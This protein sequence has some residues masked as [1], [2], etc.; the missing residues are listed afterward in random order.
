ML[1]TAVTP[2]IRADDS[3]PF[4]R[5]KS[6]YLPIPTVRRIIAI[7]DE[8][9]RDS[10]LQYSG[11]DRIDTE[12]SCAVQGLRDNLYEFLLDYDWD[13][14]DAI[15]VSNIEEYAIHECQQWYADHHIADYETQVIEDLE[16][17]YNLTKVEILADE[18]IKIELDQKLEFDNFWN[19][20]ISYDDEFKSNWFSLGFTTALSKETP[21]A[22][23]DA[24]LLTETTRF[25]EL[26]AASLES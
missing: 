20:T 7:L 8:Y 10:T 19:E 21:V 14:N 11:L 22:N 3:N 26:F 4:R 12:V 13:H 1:Q 5:A 9:E 18:E 2:V 23:D 25:F 15:R 6:D 24:S 17:K 16:A